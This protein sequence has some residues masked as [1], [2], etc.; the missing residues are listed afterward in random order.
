MHIFRSGFVDLDSTHSYLEHKE[1]YVK[2]GRGKKFQSAVQ[3]CDSFI[4]D[5]TVTQISV[6]IYLQTTKCQFSFI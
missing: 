3:Q 1:K 5:P 4:A 6:F 2:K